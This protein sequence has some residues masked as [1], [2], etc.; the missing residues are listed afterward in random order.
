[1]T[2]KLFNRLTAIAFLLFTLASCQ[3]KRKEVNIQP[4]TGPQ[5]IFEN[6]KSIYTDSA[7]TRIKVQAPKE[8]EFQN[9]DQEFPEGIL[10]DFF[11]QKTGE[12]TSYLKGNHARYIKEKDIYIVTGDVLVQSL[13]EKKKL[14]SEELIW[15]PK[16]K[17][18]SSEKFVRIE[19]PEEIVTGDG[20]VANEDFSEYKILKVRMT[21][22][23]DE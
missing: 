15:N 7:I 2:K 13:K 14:N 1:M 5:M 22:Y 23:L 18:I 21:L 6:L 12:Q 3:D 4:Y 16:T 20:L 11:D 10:V 9:G 17:K 19:T 8:L